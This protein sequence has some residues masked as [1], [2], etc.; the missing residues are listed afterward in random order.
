MIEDGT[1]N[2]F[3]MDDNYL[4]NDFLYSLNS[5]PTMFVMAGLGLMFGSLSDML[6]T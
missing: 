1:Q 6:I 2:L 3:L 5:F 4:R